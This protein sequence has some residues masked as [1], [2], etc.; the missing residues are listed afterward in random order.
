VPERAITVSLKVKV[1]ETIERT[2]HLVS[3]VPANR[4]EWRPELLPGLQPASE[5]GSLLGH[6]LDCMSGFC[7]A[8]HAAFPRELSDFGEL[9]SMSVNQCCSP[10]KARRNIAL[11][12][13]RIERGFQCC[14]DSDLNGKIQT[15][16]VPQGEA[17]LTILLGN[18]EHLINH[19]YQLFFYLKLVGLPVNSRDIYVWR[20][21]SSQVSP[22]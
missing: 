15:V 21:V 19:K 17:L 13:A 11:Y 3:L 22:R 20:G 6:L 8:F 1:L 12:A 9:R 5:V 14:A 7:A 10:E 16:F 18:L 4:L 2:D